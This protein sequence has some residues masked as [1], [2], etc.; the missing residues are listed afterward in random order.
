MF[1]TAIA[2]ASAFLIQSPDKTLAMQVSRDGSQFTVR[3]K[4][5]EIIAPSPLGLI[6]A[7]AP[8]Y[9]GLTPVE[10]RRD[11]VRQ[12]TPLIATKAAATVED[13]NR[14][15]LTYREKTGLRRRISLEIRAYNEGVA[16][17]YLLPKGQAYKVR[18]ERTAF[19]FGYDP[20]CEVSDYTA[21]HESTWRATPV[22]ALKDG[23]ALDIPVVCASA[24]Q[25]THFA[26]TQSALDGYTGSSLRAAPGG[27][28]VHLAPHPD[29][30]HIAVAA[31]D[32]LTSA[33]RVVMTAD[34]AGDLIPSELVG[35]L[36]PAPQG[37]FSWVRPGKA[38]WDWWSGPT[39]GEKPSMA[40]YERFIDFAA[41]SGFPYFLIDAGW[42][43][44]STPCCTVDPNTDI[45]RA[46]PGIDM[47]ELVRYA[48]ERHVGL[49]LW[50]HWRH[51]A[52]RVDQVLD[53]YQ[54]WGIKGVKI[55]F[56]ERDDQEMVDFFHK[57]AAATAQRHMLLDMHGAY[58]PAGLERTYPNFI[59]Q[60]GVLGAEYN[61]FSDRV[62]PAHN[63]RL[64]YTR[65]LL[66]P[67]D[68]TPGGFHNAT[69]QTFKVREVMPMTQSTRG[70]ALAMYVVYDSPLQ[71]VSDDPASYDGQAGFDFIKSVPT[72]WDETRFL[73]GTPETC[74]ALARRKGKV[75]YIGAMTNDE[76]R[77]L[78][79]PLGF[80][81]KGAYSAKLWQDGADAN[82][83]ATTTQSVTANDSLTLNL[84]PAGGAVVVLTPQ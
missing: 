54:R 61:K 15:I 53:V 57:M 55:D 67:M 19:R 66:G 6:P 20:V 71:M 49:I 4:G 82:A 18:D 63:V 24:S 7:D 36:A 13:Y 64:A 46:E 48:A 32:G 47:P 60:E 76:G 31:A 74:V 39:A 35:D 51:I 41:A 38:A 8:D 11:H 70:Q 1:I 27:F 37:D 73:D 21:S 14:L 69:P 58:P 68:Y 40:R 23:A 77:R 44:G 65:M 33:W 34:R 79:L 62:T 45:T 80:L 26:I 25:R 72:A 78:A 29:D 84:K 56:T 59:T 75:W 12:A 43:Y 2:A 42:A 3:R 50:A 9:G 30:A 10:A 52:P 81:G 83:V 16:F 5:E 22:S 28:Q 17:R